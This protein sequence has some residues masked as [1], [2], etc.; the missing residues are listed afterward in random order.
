MYR[1]AQSVQGCTKCA[2]VH[3]VCRGKTKCA[4]GH[5]IQTQSSTLTLAS[6]PGALFEAA[7]PVRATRFHILLARVGHQFQIVFI[8][9]SKRPSFQSLVLA[10]HPGAT[11]KHNLHLI[12][13]RVITSYSCHLVLI[14]T[15]LTTSPQWRRY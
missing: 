12:C 1:G 7:G 5:N 6:W 8:S 10:I 11:I 4:G 9:H 13:F 3:E 15:S 14:C 2:G